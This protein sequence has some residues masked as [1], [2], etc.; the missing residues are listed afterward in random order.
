LH[1]ARWHGRVLRKDDDDWVKNVLLTYEG[2]GARQ[3]ARPRKTWREIVDKDMDNLHIKPDA[4]DG[5]KCTVI[6][7]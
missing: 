2:E 3:T 4:V 7:D 6:S 5:R 1:S